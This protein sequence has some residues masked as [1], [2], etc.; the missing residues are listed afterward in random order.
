M[1]QLSL[2][3]ARVIN[4][5]LTNIAQ[6]IRQND[7]IGQALFPTVPVSLRAG[8][9]ITFG[10]EDFMQYSGLQRAPGAATRRVQFG[11]AGSPFALLDYSLEGSLPIETMQEGLADAKGFS[12]DGAAMAIAKVSNIMGLRLE[13]QQATLAT[14]LGNYPASNRVTLSGT[15][16]WNDYSGVSDPAAVV[17]TG[18]EAIR[19]ATGKRPNTMVLG[20]ITFARLRQHPRIRDQ[21][22][23][24]DKS[25]ITI[26]MLSEFFGIPNIYVGD[27][28]QATDAGVLSDVWGKHA[29]LAYT[30]LGPLAAMGTPTFG[31]TYN[32]DGYPIVEEPYYE[33][34][35]KTWYFPVTRSEAPVIAGSSAGYFIQNA[36]A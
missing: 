30:E 24:T 19:T 32:L 12:I 9:I 8:N 34:N 10:R 22:K 6:G 13:I 28:V 16:Q 2:A 36:V 20:P 5:V 7:L 1:P 11:Y 14:T 21:Y 35:P 25:Q 18:K 31:Y 27:A 23:Y 3:Q 4:P 29:I 15:A 33:R 17:E 26:A